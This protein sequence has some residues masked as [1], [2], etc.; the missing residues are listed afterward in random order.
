MRFRFSMCVLVALTSRQPL[1]ADANVRVEVLKSGGIAIYR[2]GITTPIFAFNAPLAGRP[3]VHPLLSPDGK[4]TLTEF[5]PGHHRHQTGI[6][7]GF[8]KVNGRDYFHN[9]GSENFRLRAFD[10]KN[11]PQGVVWKSTYDLLDKNKSAQL[12]ETQAWVFHDFTQTYLIDLTWTAKAHTDVTF[13]KHDY[14]GL[15]IR[16]PFKN[17]KD[18]QAINSEGQINGKAEGQKAKWVDIGMSVPG[19][20][21]AAHIAVL[22]QKSVPWRVDGQL[23]VG[24]SPSRAGEWK[25]A[26]GRDTTLRYR[27]YVY[28]G[29]FQRDQVEAEWKAFSAIK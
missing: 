16:M 6:Y 21:G 25:I 28:T 4:G 23:G 26:K 19:R 12:T 13:G 22:S 17:Q 8:L 7:V 29:E 2:P 11:D 20:K 18:A 10:Y 1:L 24:P 27:F 15:F 3:Y 14:G 5:S 9:R